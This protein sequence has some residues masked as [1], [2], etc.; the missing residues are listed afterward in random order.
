M[1]VIVKSMSVGRGTGKRAGRVSITYADSAVK[2]RRY[3]RKAFSTDDPK[4]EVARIGERLFDGEMR[5]LPSCSCMAHEAYY[6]ACLHMH[7]TPQEIMGGGGDADVLAGKRR[8]WV[9]WFVS[10]TLN[11]DH[12]ASRYVLMKDVH[13]V[14]V[15][16][17]VDDDA[18]VTGLTVAKGKPNFVSREQSMIVECLFPDSGIVARPI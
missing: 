3:A 15:R 14:H 6:L 9:D 5:F 18:N 10:Q 13:P 11:G 17:D 2:P 8:D 7:A 4:G 1:C 16:F 12:D